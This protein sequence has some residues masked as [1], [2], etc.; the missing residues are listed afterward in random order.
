MNELLC[1]DEG[2]GL[3]HWKVSRGRV[4]AGD[5]AG[6]SNGRG[7]II[8][9]VDGKIYPAHRIAWFLKTGEWPT[10]VIDHINRDGEDNR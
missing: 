6:T 5:L 7:Y 2:T 9:R 8:V 1:Y 4:R 3:L 10:G